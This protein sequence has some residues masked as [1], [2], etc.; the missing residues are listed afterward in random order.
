MFFCVVVV[1][2][3]VAAVGEA[4]G[5]S[6]TPHLLAV[7]WLSCTLYVLQTL[8]RGALSRRARAI[9]PQLVRQEAWAEAAIG[10]VGEPVRRQPRWLRRIPLVRALW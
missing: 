10:S 4:N 9:E 8:L 5:L 2:L 6:L 7:V 1:L 3:S